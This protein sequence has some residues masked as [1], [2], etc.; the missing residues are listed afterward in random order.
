MKPH[1]DK[2][3]DATLI[4][5]LPLYAVHKGRR[6]TI[7]RRSRGEDNFY[8]HSSSL[9]EVRNF[10]PQ[11]YSTHSKVLIDSTHIKTHEKFIRNPSHRIE[12]YSFV[13]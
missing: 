3:L 8:I 9:P 11:I 1:G 13:N 7:G 2:N 5:I 10:F 6:E 4:T 12:S